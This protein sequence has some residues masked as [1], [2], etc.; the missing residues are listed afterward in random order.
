MRHMKVRATGALVAFAVATAALVLGGSALAAQAPVPLGNAAPFGAISASGLTNGGGN[1]VISGDIGSSG[2]IDAGVTNPGFATY[3]AGSGPLANAQADLGIAI[4]NASAQSPTRD[5]TGVNLAGQVLKAGVFNSTSTI[6][7][8]GPATLTLDGN[9]NADS[10]FI[11]QAAPGATGDLTVDN[12]TNVTYTNGAQPC[13][14]FWKVH[15]AFLSNSGFAFVGTILAETQITLTDNITVQGRTLALGTNVTFIHD[16]VTRPAS[17]V[18]QA[19]VDAQA[20]ANAEAASNAQRAAET[21]AANALADAARA[22]AAADALAATQAAA[23][24]KA[25]A[26]VAAKSAADAKIAAAV[27]KKAAA[28]KDAK[29]AKA[30]AAKAVAAAKVAA[31]AKAKAIALT[32]HNLARPARRHVGLTG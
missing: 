4:T 8:H 23:I 16:V 10:V 14:V 12:G 2:A 24:A 11:F 9:G 6:T 3:T 22:Q 26:D 18:T 7:I 21:A 28:A 27:A 32:K 19:S 31:R 15:S 20:A 25:A 5:I 29:A 13:N 30:A 17:C 1:T